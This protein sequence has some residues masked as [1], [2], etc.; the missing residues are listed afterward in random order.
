MSKLLRRAL[1]GKD[2][3]PAALITGVIGPAEKN[4]GWSVSWAG[5]GAW[6]PNL[7]APT[8]TQAA[9]Q[10]AAA[11]AALYTAAPPI[12]GAEL[13]LAIYPWNYRGGPMF[14]IDGHPGSFTA[15]DIQGSDLTVYG[16]TLED[17]ASAVEHMP[18][19]PADDS[20]FR[21][22]RQITSLHG[23]SP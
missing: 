15:H 16:A 6:P 13:Q 23:T 2:R 5:D 20:M 11:V 12:P 17:L 4:G 9:G 19:I 1:G 7:H 8:L 18:D 21:W 10:A 22:I 14:D 3:Q